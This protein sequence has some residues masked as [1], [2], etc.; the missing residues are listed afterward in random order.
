MNIDYKHIP[1][2]KKKTRQIEK[3]KNIYEF[4]IQNSPQQ[5]PIS[6]P[7][8]SDNP[9]KKNCIKDGGYKTCLKKC[10]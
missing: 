6:R 10:Y 1:H 8:R 3:K 4:G 7:L 2:N 5:T 9:F